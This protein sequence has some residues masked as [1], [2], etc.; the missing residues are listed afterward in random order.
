M[1]RL[2]VLWI[3]RN[4]GLRAGLL[5]S[6]GLEMAAQRGLAARVGAR[7]E[8]F[9]DLLQHLDVG[10]DALR[11]DRPSGRR[12]I[13]RRGQPQRPIARAE[14]NDGLHR[15]LADPPRAHA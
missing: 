4:I 7:L 6:F 15:T 5:V 1:E 11:L 8:F 12:E 2:V 10:R 3:W 13:A 9:G 14:R